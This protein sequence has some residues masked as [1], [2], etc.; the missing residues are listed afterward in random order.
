MPCNVQN[1]LSKNGNDLLQSNICRGRTHHDLKV[2]GLDHPLPVAIQELEV[3]KAQREGDLGGFACLQA[4]ALELA[5][6]LFGRDDGAFGVIDVELGYLVARA[7]AHIL[8]G[9]LDVE[10]VTAQRRDGQ[11]AVLELGV[12]QTKAEAK[13]ISLFSQ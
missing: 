8:D 7:V 9:E 1:D 5:Q 6:E 3:V 11:A 10:A 12:G 13:T 2:T 4:D